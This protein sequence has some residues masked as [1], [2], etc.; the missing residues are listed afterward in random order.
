MGAVT[1]ETCRVNVQWN[2]SDC[3]LLHLVELLFNLIFCFW[4]CLPVGW[5]CPV[6]LKDRIKDRSCSAVTEYREREAFLNTL[7]MVT[8]HFPPKHWRLVTRLHCVVFR[9]TP[10]FSRRSENL[11][12]KI[13]ICLNLHVPSLYNITTFVVLVWKHVITSAPCSAHVMLS[14]RRCGRGKL[15]QLVGDFVFI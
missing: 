10:I 12:S 7:K 13:T 8:Q 3:I 11:T 15:Q 9:E 1:P 2:K 5:N 6:S 4:Y 14:L